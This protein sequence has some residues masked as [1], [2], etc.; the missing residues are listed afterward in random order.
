M[1]HPASDGLA[2]SFSFSGN[3]CQNV[4]M[5]ENARKGLRRCPV[6]DAGRNL[7]E[8]HDRKKRGFSALY[9]VA[10]LIIGVLALFIGL[11]IARGAL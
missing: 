8:G 10:S 7:A 5:L 4:V 6:R 9:A 2:G 1:Q 11:W 3:D